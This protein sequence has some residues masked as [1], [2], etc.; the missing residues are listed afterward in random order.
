MTFTMTD[1]DDVTGLLRAL[2][3]TVAL[4]MTVADD[5]DGSGGDKKN[6]TK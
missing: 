5:D 4:R 1:A 2:A 3:K 6:F